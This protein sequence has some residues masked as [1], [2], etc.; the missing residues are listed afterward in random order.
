MSVLTRD[1]L[2]IRKET[3]RYKRFFLLAVIVFVL[4]GMG[5]LGFYLYSHQEKTSAG[6][7]VNRAAGQT[8][9]KDWLLKYFGTDDENSPAVG[10]PEGDPD[11]DILT[12]EQEFFFGTDPTNPDTDGD[13][14]V[15]GAEVAVNSNPLGEGELYPTDELAQRIVD[16]YLLANQLPEFR[17]ENIEKQVL[18]ILNPPDLAT[19]EVPLPDPKTLKI[20]NDNSPEAISAYLAAMDNA[21]QGFDFSEDSL[22]NALE[23][24]DNPASVI[25]TAEIYEIINELRNIPVPSDFTKF[26]QLHIAGLFAAANVFEIQKTINPL[27][28]VEQ[29]KPKISEQYYNIMVIQKVDMLLQEE[30]VALETK[31]K[32]QIEQYEQR[33]SS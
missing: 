22:I 32:N 5:A 6:Q 18:G 12:N 13:G 26:H 24:P 14:Q 20:K 25:T 2:Q 8:L 3:V 1:F 29:E 31:Y 23:N 7:F 33:N 30:A 21:L 4:A 10:G 16:Q 9:P 17:K 28:D 19:L 27:A 11:I 15:D